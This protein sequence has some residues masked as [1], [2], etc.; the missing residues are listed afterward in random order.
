MCSY[1]GCE[2]IEVIG[3]FMAEHVEIINAT[4][5]LRSAVRS[6]DPEAVR[7]ASLA[8]SA[9]LRPHTAAEEGGL[10]RVLGRDE[11][12]TEHIAGLCGEHQTLDSHLAAVRPGDELAMAR[13]E[14]ALRDHIDKED[15]GLFPAA[16]IALNGEQWTEVHD[17][18]PH[19]HGPHDHGHAPAH[20]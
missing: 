4:G 19:S 17:S 7:S 13:F 15:N 12:F 16:A 20:P 9:L 11:G 1:C 3:R 2:S 14:D 6:A 8:V 18:T 10:F 5:A